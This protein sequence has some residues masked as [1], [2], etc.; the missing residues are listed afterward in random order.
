MFYFFLCYGGFL[1]AETEFTASNSKIILVSESTTLQP[2][3]SLYLGIKFELEK[4]WHTYWEN[5]GDAGE[6]AVI[7]WSLPDGVS[8][9]EILWPGPERIPVDPLMTFGYNNEV[10]LLT[11]ISTSDKID[12]PIELNAQVSWFTC[13]DICIPQDGNV[14]IVINEGELNKSN[15]YDEIKQYV[16]KLPKE[17]LE[18]YKV[19]KLDEKYFLQST[20]EENNF[21]SIYFFPREYGLI[22]Y[23]E[24]QIYEKNENSFSLEVKASKTGMKL[25]NF[26][27]VIQ[28][29]NSEGTFFF[30]VNFPLNIQ[31]EDKNLFLLLVFAFLGGLIL[32][33]MP[34]VFPILSIKVLRFIQYSED[35]SVETYKFGLSYSLGVILSFLLIALILIGLKSSGEVIGWGFQL[36]YPLVISILFYLFIA[37]GF[38]F[39]S[40]LVIGSQ[41]GNLN[42]LVKVNNESFE[43][44]L[45]GILAVVVASPCT[46]PF[47]GS[48][49]G[50]ALL[51]PSFNSILIFLS[52]GLGFALPYFILSIKPTLL[53]FL[54]RPGPWME[55]F[56]QFM[57]FPM[58]ASAL[59]LLWVLSG[60]V[61]SDTVI[62]VLIGGLALSLS[63]W[64][65]EKNTT[66]IKLV[67]WILR[68]TAIVLIGFSIYIIPTS[69]STKEEIFT[70]DEI[71]SEQ[72]LR[73]LRKSNQIV[74]LNFTADWCI[75]C[76]VNERVALK[77][78]KVQK[79]LD[80]ES[81][82]YLEADWTRKDE[83]IAS[84]LEE[85]GRSGV[86]LYLLY[87][88]KGKPIILPEILTEDILIKYL[89]EVR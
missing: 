62:L 83:I 14:S 3:D 79:I 58:W 86:P 59:W 18:N 8:S 25:P 41:L 33:I 84:K 35:S 19:E 20:L 40:N 89:L 32:N 26:D 48:A 57:A 61:D 47:M 6:G 22:D 1:A 15:D 28:A 44:F 16:D 10:I 34:C 72:R 38:L 65:L 69:Y 49:I 68:G 81:I 51:Q 5:P 50:F 27:G 42:S 88:S 56:K 21:D 2:K 13:K 70:K 71:Y 29:I 53:S 80:S 52:L 78:Q 85:F 37:L 66:E 36:Q 63:L 87:P 60:Q 54:P 77:T 17:F 73:E 45:T 11:K 31:N 30:D 4:D 76:K 46:A 74:F 67:K 43:S 7:K 75:T 23:V 64:L 55:T 39:M 9:S 24:N 82:N 12:F